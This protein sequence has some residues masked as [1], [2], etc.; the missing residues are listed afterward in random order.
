LHFQLV[1]GVQVY[2]TFAY[3]ISFLL[4]CSLSIQTFSVGNVTLTAFSMAHEAQG[5]CFNRSTRKTNS[6][7]FIGGGLGLFVFG[8]NEKDEIVKGVRRIIFGFLG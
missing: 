3:F 6:W 8:V 5:I 1:E 2:H 4:S 7:S